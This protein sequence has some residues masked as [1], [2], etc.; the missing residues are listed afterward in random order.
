MAIHGALPA[1]QRRRVVPSWPN[2]RE[3]SE[4]RALKEE[5]WETMDRHQLEATERLRKDLLAGLVRH[6]A[7]SRAG[8]MVLR[9]RPRLQLTVGRHPG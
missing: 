6:A 2:C 1:H 7:R 5:I 8:A 9:I 4:H 3:P